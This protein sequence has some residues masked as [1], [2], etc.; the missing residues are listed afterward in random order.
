MKKLIAAGLMCS[1][2]I[3]LNVTAAPRRFDCSY[4]PLQ[5]VIRTARDESDII[6]LIN[7]R[8]N[9]NMKQKCGGTVLQLAV[10]RGNANIVKVLLE[11]GN[12]P[13]DENVSLA[14][15]P[16]PGAPK[17]IPMAFFAAYYSPRADIMKLFI[18]A[19]AN[20][21]TQDSKGENILWYLNQN[22]VLS[23]TDLS[24]EIM[25]Q[26]LMKNTIDPQA[27]VSDEPAVKENDRSM[28]QK[29]ER[30]GA[31]EVSREENAASSKKQA[32]EQP[33]IQK[34]QRRQVIDAEPDRPFKPSKEDANASILNQSDF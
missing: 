1:C 2:L 6:K 15:F 31:E 4:S 26:L 5:Q 14:D 23:N 32:A 8:V 30:R 11:N 9:L 7:N 33:V 28:V 22:P 16:I 20:I 18:S 19:G 27:A 12:L 29:E 3:T 10:L 24:D 34:Q 25:Q 17:E 21:L 13:L